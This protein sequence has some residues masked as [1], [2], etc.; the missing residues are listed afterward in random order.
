MSII[1]KAHF[2]ENSSGDCKRIVKKRAVFSSPQ[3]KLQS[4]ASSVI[5]MDSTEGIYISRSLSAIIMLQA[6]IVR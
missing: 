4:F 3:L 5:N 1:Y 6:V 2:L